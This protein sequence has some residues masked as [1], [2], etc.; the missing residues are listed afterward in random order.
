MRSRRYGMTMA[1]FLAAAGMFHVGTA[2]E[3]AD[4]NGVLRTDKYLPDDKPFQC[5]APTE[6]EIAGLQIFDSL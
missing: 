5:I 3:R 1:A 2:A 6:M 4:E